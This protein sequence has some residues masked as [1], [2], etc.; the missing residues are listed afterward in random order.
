MDGLQLAQH[1]SLQLRA[2]DQ[3][4]KPLKTLII[5]G[6]TNPNELARFDESGLTV[7]A[8]P[9]RSERLLEHLNARRPATAKA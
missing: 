2:H 7:L 8:K 1:V 5:S 9:F 3:P 4:A 6:D